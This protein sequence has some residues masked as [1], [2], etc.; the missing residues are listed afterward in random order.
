VI[1]F[2]LPNGGGHVSPCCMSLTPPTASPDGDSEITD[3]RLFI[4]REFVNRCRKN[5]RYSLRAFA[6]SLGI[7][8]SPLSAILRGKRPISAKMKKRLGLALGFNLEELENFGGPQKRTVKVQQMTLDNYAIIADWYH[9]AILELIKVKGFKS[10]PDYIAKALNIG[11]TEAHIAI[12]RLKRVGLLGINRGR[13]F[14]TTAA[15]LLSNI[16]TEQTGPAN[17]KLQKQILEMSIKSLEEMPLEVRNQTSITVAI[18]SEDLPEA[19]KRI[20]NFRRELCAFFESNTKP[21]H[22][23]HLGISLYP[24]SVQKDIP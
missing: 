10:S 22:V 20:Q 7:E 24:V 9:Y 5:P 16:S 8:P 18:N 17:K 4:Q 3:F 1:D 11:M 19:K 2:V 15:V 23:Y 13:W 14:D 21:T 12:E 6:K